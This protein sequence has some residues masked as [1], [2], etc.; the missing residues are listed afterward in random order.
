M[1][2]LGFSFSEEEEED[3]S[4]LGLSTSIPRSGVGKSGGEIDSQ[5]VDPHVGGDANTPI[6][7]LNANEI[8]STVCGGRIGAVGAKMCILQTCS[9][10]S[11]ATKKVVL[12]DDD[13]DK[14]LAFI[15]AA[16]DQAVF[17]HPYVHASKLGEDLERCLADKRSVASWNSLFRLINNPKEGTTD[18]LI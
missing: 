15:V 16:P 6:I 17:T 8:G 12:P 9:F 14:I 1:S 10:S 4:S 2:G 18:Q 13:A 7:C 3:Y 5:I 11:H